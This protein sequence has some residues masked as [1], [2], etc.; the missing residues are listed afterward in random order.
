MI[1][2]VTRSPE[3][4]ARTPGVPRPL[5]TV[6]TQNPHDDGQAIKGDEPDK[7]VSRGPWRDGAREPRVDG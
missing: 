6:W 1:L 4:I 3:H 5:Y 7:E 2:K